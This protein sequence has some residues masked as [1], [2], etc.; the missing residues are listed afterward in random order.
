MDERIKKE[1]NGKKPSEVQDLLLDNCKATSI[2]GLTDEFTQ[3]TTLSLINVGLNSLDGLPKLPALRTIDLSDNKLTGGLEKLAQN[4]PR[5]YHL[6]LCA[7]KIEAI[8]TLEPLKELTELTALDLFDCSV[9]ELPQYRKDVFTLLPQ[10][11]YL[12]GFDVND[13]EADLS[14]DFG[15]AE[16]A[17]IGVEE[18]SDEDEFDSHDEEELAYLNSSKAVQDEDESEDYVDK[19]KMATANGEK[20][21]GAGNIP[22]EAVAA[23]NNNNAR[24]RKLEEASGENADGEP[25]TKV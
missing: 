17:G 23:E 8:K 10:I 24:K 11:R 3:L 20:K 15:G 19:A 2:S 16:D 7:N 18:G 25:K 13:E 14:D 5:L 21:N 22:K 4:C 9:T 1:L 12:D 6:N